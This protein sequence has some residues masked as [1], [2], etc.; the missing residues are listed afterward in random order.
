MDFRI[1]GL[2]PESFRPLFG[3][4]D[5]EL[6]RHGAVRRL[7]D[8]KPGY[9]D[10][11]ELRDADIGE[12]VLLVNFTHLPVATPYRSS[13][14][15]YVREGAIRPYQRGAGAVPLES[16]LSARVRRERH[17][18]R[19]RHRGRCRDR[20]PHRALSVESRHRVHP[21]ALREIRLLRSAYRSSIEGTRRDGAGRLL[22]YLRHP[23]YGWAAQAA[24][25]LRGHSNRSPHRDRERNRS[26]PRSTSM[27]DLGPR[28]SANVSGSP[29]GTI[30][31]Q[32]G[33]PRSSGNGIAEPWSVQRQGVN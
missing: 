26:V 21:C 32:I 10:R 16:A 28:P 22:A 15:I 11:I 5:T 12:S 3:L 18:P 6:A 24:Q 14:A 7:V 17:A 33:W 19:C 29:S 9:P 20:A 25:P 2:S 8:C 1:T 30:S 23:S 27:M 31:H 13:Y 4:A